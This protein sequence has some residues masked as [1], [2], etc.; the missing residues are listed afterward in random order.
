MHELSVAQSIFEIVNQYV[1]REQSGSVKSI[2]LKLGE[3]SGVVPDSLEFCFSA[4]V[5]DTP[6][7]AAR[8]EI[9]RVPFMLACKTCKKSFASQFGVVLCPECGGCETDVISGTEM[10]I[11]EIEIYELVQN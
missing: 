9:E 2:K 7:S 5:V 10:Q 6:L 11:V 1:L 8:L 4:I 3:F